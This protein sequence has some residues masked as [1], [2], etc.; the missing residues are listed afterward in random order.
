[1]D[2]QRNRQSDLRMEAAV[3]LLPY[4]ALMF[5]LLLCAAVPATSS[6]HAGQAE[7]KQCDAGR[8]GNAI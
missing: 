5:G 6:D 4:L 7:A 8:L 2:A 1:M 3:K